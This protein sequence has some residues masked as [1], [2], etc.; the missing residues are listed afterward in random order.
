MGSI[1][2]IRL[3]LELME[4]VEP[5]FWIVLGLIKLRVSLGEVGW[6]DFCSL[7][8]YFPLEVSCGLEVFPG[9]FP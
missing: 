8:F 3:F 2:L 6:M 4:V 5:G 7:C 9:L 1:V